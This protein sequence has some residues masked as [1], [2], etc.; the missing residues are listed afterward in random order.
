MVISY[1]ARARAFRHETDHQENSQ[2][3]LVSMDRSFRLFLE[4]QIPGRL[5]DQQPG[6]ENP[7]SESVQ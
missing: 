1:G 7:D 2:H 4:V 6:F 5:P 3:D